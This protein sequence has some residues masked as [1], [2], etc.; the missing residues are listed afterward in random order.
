MHHVFLWVWLMKTESVPQ[1]F[2]QTG[3]VLENSRPDPTSVFSP[4][5]FVCKGAPKLQYYSTNLVRTKNLA[6]GV[7]KRCRL[8]WLTNSGLVNEPKC[9]GRGRGGVSANEYSCA[10]GDQINFGDLT[11]YI[12]MA[13]PLRIFITLLMHTVLVQLHTVFSMSVYM[14]NFLSKELYGMLKY[15][16]SHAR[17]NI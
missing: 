3:E 7:T 2:A 13:W 9:G 1:S 4:A 10:H 14:D 8:S 17:R 5:F 6:Q 16:F 12:T 15:S 11:P